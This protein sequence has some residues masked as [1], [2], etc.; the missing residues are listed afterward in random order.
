MHTSFEALLMSVIALLIPL[1]YLSILTTIYN[2]F[3]RETKL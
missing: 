3:S 2:P 1:M